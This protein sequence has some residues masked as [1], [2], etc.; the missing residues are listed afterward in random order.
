MSLPTTLAHITLPRKLLVWLIVQVPF[1]QMNM[2]I[3][4]SKSQ[5]AGLS[6]HPD[7]QLSTSYNLKMKFNDTSG[8]TISIA[9]SESVKNRMLCQQPKKLLAEMTPLEALEP[10]GN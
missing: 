6:G 5:I 7:H 9:F 1:N 4:A 8:E 2:P 3:C 10:K